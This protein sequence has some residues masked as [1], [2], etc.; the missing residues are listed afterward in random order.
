MN[1]IRNFVY[2]KYRLPIFLIVMAGYIS[3]IAIAFMHI[4]IIPGIIFTGIW[5]IWSIGCQIS[6]D[7]DMGLW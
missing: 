4:T 5:I 3:G 7:M 1:S 2:K 6:N